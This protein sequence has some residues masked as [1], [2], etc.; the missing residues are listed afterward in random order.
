MKTTVPTI[1]PVA[2]L[3]EA[4]SKICIMLCTGCC[5]WKQVLTALGIVQD[6]QNCSHCCQCVTYTHNTT[7]HNSMCIARLVQLDTCC[8]SGHSVGPL[9]DGRGLHL[10]NFL[11]WFR[12]TWKFSKYIVCDLWLWPYCSGHPTNANICGTLC[13]PLPS[14]HILY[15]SGLSISACSRVVEG[16]WQLLQ[17]IPC[18]LAQFLATLPV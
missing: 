2:V 12:L 1:A 13:S 17:H 11:T 14:H 5:R 7:Q 18:M 9:Q 4:P 15:L 16:V 3:A 6:M 10:L 8:T